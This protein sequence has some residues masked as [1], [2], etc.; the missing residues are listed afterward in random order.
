[1]FDLA[2]GPTGGAARF[3]REAEQ[4]VAALPARDVRL[5][6]LARRLGPGW[7]VARELIEPQRRRIAANN[8]SFVTGRGPRIVLLN[9]ALHFL[10][11]GE[12]DRLPGVPADLRRQS[13]V[14]LGAA[15]R[16]DV[17]VVPCT[18]MAE[19][20]TAGLPRVASRVVVRH[21]PYTVTHS[22][23]PGD[24]TGYV[25]YPSIPAPHKDL[26]GGV[27]LLAD[28]IAESGLDLEVRVTCT[29]AD[30]AN[31]ARRLG[32]RAIG[33]QSLDGLDQLLAGAAL[34]FSPYTTESYGY[35]V[36]EARA[37]GVPVVGVDTAQNREIGS[38]ALVGFTA[39]DRDSLARAL[40]VA[41]ATSVD[42]DPAP[43]EAAA[44]FAWL[45]TLT[46]ATEGS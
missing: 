11:P 33:P 31:V 1:M 4:W 5:V 20:V 40:E 2:G 6:G 18:D 24:G 7:L 39:G 25:L 10:R 8:V 21:Q 26:V 46:S 44:Y 15:L 37:V 27:Q 17:I 34:V 38:R 13:R 42:P 16:A 41:V 14:V 32:V 36:A 29:D 3:R 43:F 30:L 23:R 28:A 12:I 19:R 45:T 35:P 22:R 9:N